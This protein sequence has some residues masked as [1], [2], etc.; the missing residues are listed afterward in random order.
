MIARVER[1]RKVAAPTP[2][3]QRKGRR[4]Q[5]TRVKLPP[6]KESGPTYSGANGCDLR[7]GTH[8]RYVK[9]RSTG[10]IQK[11]GPEQS[12]VKWHRSGITQAEVNNHLVRTE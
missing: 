3:V 5:R 11:A 1:K 7:Q 6:A 8:V 4:V 2:R 12:E 10:T 9:G